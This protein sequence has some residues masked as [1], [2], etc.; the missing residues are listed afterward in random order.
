MAKSIFDPAFKYR[1]SCDTSVADTFKR[2]RKEL[3][4]EKKRSEAVIAEA[5]AV[6][7]KTRIVKRGT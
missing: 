6:V 4:A 5:A 2:I 3:D 1:P 7:A